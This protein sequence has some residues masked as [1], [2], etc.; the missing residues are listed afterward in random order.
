MLY[1]GVVG[2][3]PLARFFGTFT[4]LQATGVL[5]LMLPVVFAAAWMWHGVKSRAPHAASLVLLF[6]GIAFVYEFVTRPW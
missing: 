5:L 2:V 6:L 3:S 4:F 1:G